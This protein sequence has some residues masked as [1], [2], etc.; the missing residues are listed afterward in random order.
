MRTDNGSGINDQIV[1]QIASANI[2]FANSPWIPTAV[3]SSN[4]ANYRNLYSEVLGLVSQPQ[5]SQLPE[6]R[7]RRV[8]TNNSTGISIVLQSRRRLCRVP[9]LCPRL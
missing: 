4:Q 2:N 5:H 6:P 8:G 9:S 7:V 1:Y 3:P